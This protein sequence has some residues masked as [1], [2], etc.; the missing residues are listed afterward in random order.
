VQ[1]FRACRGKRSG[2][3][4]SSPTPPLNGSRL[5][6]IEG[7]TAHY[8]SDILNTLNELLSE[9][10]GAQIAVAAISADSLEKGAS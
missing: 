3:A 4:R 10:E 9:F 1:S 6:C 2:A 5:S 7:G 8:A